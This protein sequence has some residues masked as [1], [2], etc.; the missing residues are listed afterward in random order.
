VTDL[1]LLDQMPARAMTVEEE[2]LARAFYAAVQHATN[3]SAR[4]QQSADHRIGVSDLGFCSERVRRSIAGM[5]EPEVDHLPAFIGTALGD[6]VERAVGEVF[7]D[8]I[9]QAEVQIVLYGDTGSFILNGHPDVIDPAGRV[10]DVKTADGLGRVRRTGPSQQQQFQRHCYAKA[11]HA[12][13]LFHPEV[14]LADVTVSDIWFDRSARE[15]GAYVHTELYDERVVE[16]ATTWLDDVVYAYRN[17][18]RARKEPPREMCFSACGFAPDCRGGDTDVR[19]LIT[20]AEQLAAISMYREAV[21]ME[22]EARKLK[23][24]SKMALTGVNGSTGRYAV[25]WVKVAG[26]HVEF[27]RSA[28]ERLDIRPLPGA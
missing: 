18:D 28:H 21:N 20:D 3:H 22:K 25:R 11:A 10:I 19:G 9:R 27:D 13:G 14:K 5:A 16:A 15:R 12:A 7:P 4:S 2:D 17:D 6:H 26:G 1:D 23:V 24:E 8:L